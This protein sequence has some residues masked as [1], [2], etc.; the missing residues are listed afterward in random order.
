M[1]LVNTSADTLDSW[2]LASDM[3]RF[4]K[5]DAEFIASTIL[6][7]ITQDE[8]ILVQR[9][10]LWPFRKVWEKVHQLTFPKYWQDVTVSH[11][12]H[13]EHKHSKLRLY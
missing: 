4:E 1:L 13:V 2:R 10:V 8:K 9:I 7:F 3:P 11:R 6:G 5:G 12:K